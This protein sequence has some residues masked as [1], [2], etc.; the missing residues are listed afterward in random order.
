MSTQTKRASLVRIGVW[1]EIFTVLWMLLEASLSIVAGLLAHSALL[2]AFGLDSVIELISGAILLWRLQVEAWGGD[3]KHVE[4]AERR[5]ARVVF[6]SLALLCLYVFGTSFYSL[7][8][9]SQPESSPLG[10]AVAFAAVLVMPALAWGKRRLAARLGSGALRGDA[11]SSLTCGYMAATVLI[12]LV[13]NALFH[14]W[15]AEDV[16]AL[17]FLIWLVLETRE[18]LKEAR[19]NEEESKEQRGGN[20]H[21]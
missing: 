9:G 6:V 13:A 18:A 1:V 11:A 10:I 21:Q 15:W 2:V 3:A 14:W 19:G 12:G 4:Q 8:I 7:V 17:G 5:A 20:G 16:A